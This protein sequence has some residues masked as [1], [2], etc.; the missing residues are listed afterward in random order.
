MD[1][2]ETLDIVVVGAGPCG[3]S[4]GVAAA[5]EGLRC[6]LFDKG[7]ITRSISLYPTYGTFFSTADRLELGGVPFIVQGTKP[8]RVDALKYYRR[9]VEHFGL[10]VRQ[11]EAVASVER[12]AARFLVRTRRRHGEEGEYR[13]RSVVIATGYADSPNLLGVPGEELDKVSHYYTEPY[14]YFDQDCIVVGGGNSAVEAALDLFRSGAR[15]TLVH[16]LDTLDRGVKPWILPDIT[17]R[18]DRGEIDVRW[19]TRIES[20]HADRVVLRHEDGEREE[21]PN[22]FVLAMTGY[23]PD[24][25]LLRQLGVSIDPDTGVPAHDPDTMETDVPGVFIAGVIAGGNRPDQ[26][27]IE[28]GRG[29]GPRI[30]DRVVEGAA[31]APMS[32]D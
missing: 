20:I 1:K 10:D 11:Y 28:D 16:F 22:D 17:N 3:L 23:H 31:P 6:V 15:V 4:A 26:I 27:F 13:A 9:I 7:C 25:T 5:Q 32:A 14:P 29:H 19:R 18:L 24:A 30:I 8:T 2:T 21:L 12:Q